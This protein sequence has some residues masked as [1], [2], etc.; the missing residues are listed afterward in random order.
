VLTDDLRIQPQALSGGRSGS[1]LATVGSR[2]L[3]M[4]PRQPFC[5]LS[6]ESGG[7]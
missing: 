1:A 5:R 6:V 4:W 3:Q 2:T 7:P